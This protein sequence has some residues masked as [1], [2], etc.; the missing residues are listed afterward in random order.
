MPSMR[1][2]SSLYTLTR[3]NTEIKFLL[4]R[5]IGNLSSINAYIA[6][7]VVLLDKKHINSFCARYK[8]SVYY[9]ARTHFKQVLQ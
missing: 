6:Y 2:R 4:G 3:L 9:Y 7:V 5:K 1:V 8:H